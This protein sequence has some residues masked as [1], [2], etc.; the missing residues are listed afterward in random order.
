MNSVN[1]KPT[2]K[3]IIST[4]REEMGISL[5]DFAKPLGVSHQSI[6]QWEEGIA[7]PDEKRL[8]EWMHSET[9]WVRELAIKI[10]AIRK[11]DVMVLMR[12]QQ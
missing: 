8:T 1:N 4:T 6:V 11:W 7:T 10:M 5:R 9:Y 3:E 12:P 2:A